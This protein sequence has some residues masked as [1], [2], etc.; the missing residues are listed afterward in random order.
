MMGGAIVFAVA[1]G[2]YL[3]LAGTIDTAELV[4]AFVCASA[5]TTMAA[6]LAFVAVRRFRFAPPTGAVWRPIAALLPETFIVGRE[7]V[8]VALNGT[9]R[10]QGDF[11]RQ[12]FEAAGTDP[13][14]HGR[15]A[16]VVLGISL[17]PRSFVLRGERDD[18]LLLHALPA[19][20]PSTDTAWP[21]L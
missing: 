5:A 21:A 3:F 10:Q 12:P 8:R 2:S 4:A 18:I 6:G 9:D 14:S 19:K 7:L 15:R 20:P 11:V 13:L 1:F 16:L 17:A